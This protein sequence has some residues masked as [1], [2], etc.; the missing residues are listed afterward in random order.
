MP[1]NKKKELLLAMNFIKN[2]FACL[3]FYLLCLPTLAQSSELGIHGKIIQADGEEVPF[4]NVFLLSKED[5]SIVKGVAASLEGEDTID[6]IKP[7]TF[8]I[9]ATMVGYKKGFSPVFEYTGGSLRIADLRLD[10]EVKALE[11]V[12][13][14]AQKPFIE[15]EVDRTVINVENSIDDRGP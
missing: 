2:V 5:S 13:V 4:A 14:V 8:L 12:K 3:P 11:E 10:V 9:M 1:T 15:Q 7:G 6:D